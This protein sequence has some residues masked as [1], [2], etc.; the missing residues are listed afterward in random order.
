MR[1]PKIYGGAPKDL[2]HIAID[3]SEMMYW[4][5]CP[6]KKPQSPLV[7][8]PN[9]D[10]FEPLMRR[11]IY[12]ACDKRSNEWVYNGYVYVTAKTMWVNGSTANRPGWHSDGFL[13]DDLNFIW[14]NS[15]PT[16]FCIDQLTDF[17]ADHELSL[18][19]MQQWADARPLKHVRYPVEHLSMLDEGVIH[20]VDDQ[21]TPGIRTFVKISISRHPYALKGNSINHELPLN[22]EYLDRQPIRNCPTGASN[23]KSANT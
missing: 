4:L 5:Y 22:V 17:V 15:S 11:A 10:R 3:T 9:L 1:T 18:S 23:G 19:E 16:V 8:P 12:H 13:T 14:M 6:I 7:I 20:K 21:M 2:G